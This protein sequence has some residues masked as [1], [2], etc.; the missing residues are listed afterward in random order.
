VLRGLHDVDVPVSID[1]SKPAVM[2]AALDAGAS[3][4]NDVNALRAP[5][6]LELVA[7]RG[8]AAVL[9]HMKGEP[10]TMNDAPRYDDVVAEVLAFLAARVEAAVA[11]GIPKNR[12]AIDPGLGFGKTSAD[13]LALLSAVP[14]FKTLNCA[15]LIGASGKLPGHARLAAQSGADILRIHDVK[16]QKRVCDECHKPGPVE[17]R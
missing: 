10:A 16:A 7:E 1:T 5:G 3:I 8:A 2:R 11:A 12:I 9:M 15:V 17:G 14:R 4:V 6:A 13:N